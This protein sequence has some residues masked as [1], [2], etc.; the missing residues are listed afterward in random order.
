MYISKI[1]LKNFKKF[2]DVSFE[3][4][5][6][7]NILT[8]EN[9]CGKSSILDALSI[10]YE[11]FSK[12]IYQL[13]SGHT[14]KGKNKNLRKYDWSFKEQKIQEFQH[15]RTS[16]FNDIKT[17]SSFLKSILIG[18]I[19]LIEGEE[20][21]ISFE[22]KD[23]LV[24]V[25]PKISEND[26]LKFNQYF[27]FTDKTDMINKFYINLIMP[28]ITI[29][30]PNEI[31]ISDNHF[32]NE[33]LRGN[34]INWIKNRLYKTTNDNLGH[35]ERALQT[36]F[37]NSSISIRIKYDPKSTVEYIGVYIKGFD[38]SEYDL[39]LMGS[40][41]LQTLNIILDLYSNNNGYKLYLLDEPDSH[42]HR[43]I[44][45][46]FLSFL[47]TVS[48][49]SNIQIII[50]THSIPMI[51][52][53]NINELF[54]I[55]SNNSNITYKPISSNKLI[56]T[57][58]VGFQ[59]SN[60]VDIYSSLGIDSTSNLIDA[61]EAKKIV[62]V[63]GIDDAHIL[64]SIGK[65]SLKTNVDDIYFWTLKGAS[66]VLMKMKYYKE[67]LSL[68]SNG[69]TLW[70]KSVLVL[71]RDSLI[72][73]EIKEL[74]ESIK[75]D[76]E[77]DTFFWDTYAIENQFFKDIDQLKIALTKIT[78][79]IDIDKL[80]KDALET[81][82]DF[83]KLKSLD[84]VEYTK[85]EKAFFGQRQQKAKD[86]KKID[87]KNNRFISSIEKDESKKAS[88]FLRSSSKDGSIIKY[89]KLKKAF[90]HIAI[91]LN[92]DEMV[93]MDMLVKELPKTYFVEVS[94]FIYD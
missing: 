70:E 84:S 63:E 73:S 58:K 17:T 22:I 20:I 82:Y 12:S 86:Y 92:L 21:D 59:G 93:L 16:S 15:Y 38:S 60:K 18:V 27:S 56:L 64:K 33:L 3:L 5:S 8:G 48:K 42:L 62:F 30:Q 39:S 75:D 74:K 2:Q 37:D 55:E 53:A 88:N 71:D 66:D 77:I 52:K 67:I 34:G 36:I 10:W 81:Q 7:L 45:H 29:V 90:S 13:N 85:L 6:G 25:F 49:N 46:K 23:T 19:I 9:S 61:I 43:A 35:I 89:I 26:L 24:N 40:G 72:D 1:K 91:S 65:Y 78:D 57:D 83:E 11:C 80:M 41:F 87:F 94:D 47:Q 28:M 31:E 32:K 76:L 44:Q 79:N 51:R 4:N 50:T 68:I 14:L 54:H 69:K